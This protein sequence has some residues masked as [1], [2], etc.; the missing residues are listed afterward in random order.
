MR[1]PDFC[2]DSIFQFVR[3]V[4]FELLC[5]TTLS[6]IYKI[7]NVIDATRRLGGDLVSIK[8]VPNNSDEIRI[9]RYLSS[10]DLLPHPLN[11]C[12]SVAEILRDPLDENS[13]LMV[14]PY[15]C[16]FD[17]PE[18]Y[19]IGDVIDFIAQTLEASTLSF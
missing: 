17:D 2:E 6:I 5:F 18:L 8:I 19:A 1:H 12:V 15:L 9:A 11:H 10:P 3:Y 16:P 14:M 7:P 13:S 4:C